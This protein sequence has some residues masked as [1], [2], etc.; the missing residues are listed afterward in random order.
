VSDR[1]L[2]AE[3]AGRFLPADI[4]TQWLRLLRPAVALRYARPG[5]PVAAVL[6]GQPRLPE[7]AEWPVWKGHGPLSFIAAIDC[8]ALSAVPLD[9]PLPF[10]VLL[11]FYFDG[12][13][14][15]HQAVVGPWDPPTLV[16]AR[17]LYVRPDQA[18]SLRACP[19][20]IEPYPRV[21]LAAVPVVTFPTFEHPDLQAAFKDPAEDLDSFLGHPVNDDAFQ[22]ALWYRQVAVW[23]RPAPL[24]QVGGYAFPVQGPPE[25]DLAD[26]ALGNSEPADD[27]L[28]SAEA[29][30]WT[31]LAQLD[32]DDRAEMNLGDAG[33]LYWLTRSRNPTGGDLEKV[34]FTWQGH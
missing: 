1:E 6:G 10:G 9:I 20:G 25:Y 11:F 32:S 24:H 2:V 5:A 34:S 18:T 4:A 29:A 13:I 23:D 8:A 26:P 30:R 28:L 16:G 33:V 17:M 15:D 22:D 27:P 3:I 31:L 19:P 12:Q 21:G 7:S 14:D